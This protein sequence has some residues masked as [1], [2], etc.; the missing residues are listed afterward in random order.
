MHKYFIRN[1][2]YVYYVT[3]SSSWCL[4]L[5]CVTTCILLASSPCRHIDSHSNHKKSGFQHLPS[6]NQ[7][8]N[9]TM[10]L[11]QEITF[12]PQYRTHVSLFTFG[13]KH[14][15]HFQSYLGQHRSLP[16][17]PPLGS[18]FHKFVMY[19][20]SICNIVYGI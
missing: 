4:Q 5:W 15:I 14:P 12:Q 13:L 10:N 20:Y 18:F 11:S 19:L 8:L 6:F 17:P 16:P 1:H 2:L 3:W 7:L 9:C